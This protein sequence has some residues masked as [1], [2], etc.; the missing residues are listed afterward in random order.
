M[1]FRS[2]FQV[3]LPSPEH[4]KSVQVNKSLSLYSLSNS[5]TNIT[6]WVHFYNLSRNGQV[7]ITSGLD[8]LNGSIRLSATKY[9]IIYKTLT[10]TIR[11]RD[12]LTA[13]RHSLTHSLTLPRT[14]LP[15]KAT[16]QTQ[17]L[18][19]PH[20]HGRRYQ[21]HP[22]RPPSTNTHHIPYYSQYYAVSCYVMQCNTH[23]VKD[24]INTECVSEW[25]GQWVCT[26]PWCTR[27]SRCIWWKTVSTATEP[28]Q[29]AAPQGRIAA[30]I[31]QI[32]S[33]SWRV[34]S[35][36]VRV[37][38]EWVREWGM[39]G[40]CLACWS[41][42]MNNQQPQQ[43]QSPCRVVASIWHLYLVLRQSVIFDTIADFY[44]WY[45]GLVDEDATTLLYARCFLHRNICEWTVEVR[46]SAATPFSRP[47]LTPSLTHSA[48]LHSNQPNFP[49][50]LLFTIYTLLFT[51]L[52]YAPI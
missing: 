21:Q 25:V 16:P 18:P 13:Q 41:W 42:I 52:H 3:I 17:Y 23:K 19:M 11:G 30:K 43:K 29:Y 12:I 46:V 26:I 28:S 27:G 14:Q 33:S 6:Y 45:T 32:H 38:S 48:N 37:G 51:I 35:R 49:F 24:F 50:P 47:S 22:H 5:V 39:D 2:Q 1:D 20:R 9:T 8:R 44:I 15:Q 34:V 10:T 7:H 36:G 4:Y 31:W 40:N